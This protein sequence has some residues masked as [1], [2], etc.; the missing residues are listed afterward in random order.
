[1]NPKENRLMKSDDTKAYYGEIPA[2]LCAGKHPNFIDTNI[3]EYQYVCDTKVPL[4]RVIDSKQRL[5]NGSVF[6][7]EPAHRIVFT[8]LGYKK[9]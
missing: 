4:L 8:N 6:E 5:K 1:M 7:L 2:E 9:I 3:I